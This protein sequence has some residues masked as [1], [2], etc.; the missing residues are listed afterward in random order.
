MASAVL[1]KELVRRLVSNLFKLRLTINP[2]KKGSIIF[3]II[4][5][6]VIISLVFFYIFNKDKSDLSSNEKCFNISLGDIGSLDIN[7]DLKNIDKFRCA[8]ELGEVQY[9]V[10]GKD[11][12]GNIFYAHHLFGGVAPSGVDYIDDR[13]I[14]KNNV[15]LIS[16]KSWGNKGNKTLGSCKFIDNE[17]SSPESQYIY[18]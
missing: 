6:I 14:I 5:L 2:M 16:E 18:L 15:T 13:C 17:I 9:E 7:F 11:K 10:L 4:L 1:L 3:L 12:E 8:S